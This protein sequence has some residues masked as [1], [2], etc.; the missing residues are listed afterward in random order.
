MPS[1]HCVHAKERRERG[2]RGG[3]YSG[4]HKIIDSSAV[5]DVKDGIKGELDL[6]QR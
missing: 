1:G 4:Q 5:R 3:I 6:T 2:T